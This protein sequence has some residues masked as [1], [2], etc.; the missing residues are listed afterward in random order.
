MFDITTLFQRNSAKEA[1][2]R[3]FQQ[4]HKI[5]AF[6]SSRREGQFT[7]NRIQEHNFAPPT[8]NQSVQSFRPALY[9]Q[10]QAAM[11][12]YGAQS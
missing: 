1:K 12:P 10:C 8:F 6:M 11:I 5:T 9:V 4:I 7:I 2:R 3:H